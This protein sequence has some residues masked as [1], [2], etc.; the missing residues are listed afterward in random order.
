MKVTRVI[1]QEQTLSG[2]PLALLDVT[3]HEDENEVSD[4]AWSDEVY[5]IESGC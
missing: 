2:Q 5:V 3:F 1:P 4:F